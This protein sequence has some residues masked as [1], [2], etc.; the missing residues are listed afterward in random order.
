MQAPSGLP[1][2][3]AFFFGKQFH[4]PLHGEKARIGPEAAAG[5]VSNSKDRTQIA[6]EG[7]EGPSFLC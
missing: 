7:R 3:R 5:P 1:L 6:E 4:S 2:A